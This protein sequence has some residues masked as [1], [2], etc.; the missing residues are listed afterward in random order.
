MIH[1]INVA[2]LKEKSG[3]FSL[4]NDFVMCESLSQIPY[5]SE[6]FQSEML[7]IFFCFNGHLRMNVG[8][9][10][11]LLSAGEAYLCKPHVTVHQVLASADSNIS[12]LFYSLHIAEHVLPARLNL[13]QLFLECTSSNVRF[14]TKV[15]IERILPLLDMLRQRATNPGL[16]FQSNSLYH[17]FCILLFEVLNP[18][19]R[20]TGADDSHTD[21]F[22][23]A[24]RGD[25]LF[26]NFVKLLNEDAG[27]HRTVTYYADKLCITPKHL[28]KV[29]KAKT[30]SR[31]LEIITKHTVDLIKLDL[32]LSDTPIRQLADKYGFDNFSFFCQYVKTHLGMT[33]KEY[34]EM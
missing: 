9:E 7:M 15:M 14:G 13:S 4:E 16:P 24:N 3:V 5:V 28:S 31:A 18:L 32:K 22:P 20:I 11:A 26:N 8:E 25:A 10:V 19:F 1:T 23:S 21:A 30:H 17:L 6:A 2:G 29:I 34:R 12:V 33:P 27:R